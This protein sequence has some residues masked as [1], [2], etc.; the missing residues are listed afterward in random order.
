[1]ENG[2]IKKKKIHNGVFVGVGRKELSAGIDKTIE[3]LI[4]GRCDKSL[5]SGRREIVC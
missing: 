4:K 5:V 3:I 1:M 2:K